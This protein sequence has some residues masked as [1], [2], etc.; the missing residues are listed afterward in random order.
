MKDL[1]TVDGLVSAPKIV[2]A[3]LF[4]I[5]MLGVGAL[6]S[7]LVFKQL[8]NESFDALVSSEQTKLQELSKKQEL[9][10][11]SALYDEQIQKLESQLSEVSKQLP[12]NQEGDEFIKI[13]DA[14]IKSVGVTIHSLQR[15]TEKKEAFLITYPY[16]VIG[17]ADYHQIG[18]FVAKLS[19]ISRII[20]FD[21]FQMNNDLLLSDKST[22]SK[23]YVCSSETQLLFNAVISTY[24]YTDK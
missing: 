14:T 11:L 2:W 1:L 22:I 20:T 12:V 19:K 7:F 23:D 18:A 4:L 16:T 3:F 17:C 24:S 8:F 15:G 10:A 9:A 6:G 5:V 21:K 13:L